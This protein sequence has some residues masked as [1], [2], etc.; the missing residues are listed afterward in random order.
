[1]MS[2][3]SK[4]LILNQIGDNDLAFIHH[5]LSDSQRTQ[6]LPLGKPYPED[7]ANKWFKNRILHW[8]NNNF[9]TFIVYEK[10]SNN[11]IGFCGLEYVMDSQLIDI[12]YGL[13]QNSWGKGYAFEAAQFCITYGFETLKLDVIYGAAVPENTASLHIL[14]KVGM[15]PDLA[16]NCYGNVEEQI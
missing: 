11:C 15:K 13:I 1:M 10:D 9:G 8:K 12:R 4:R 3:Q 2:L 5:Y 7:K 6:Y 14:K 16:F